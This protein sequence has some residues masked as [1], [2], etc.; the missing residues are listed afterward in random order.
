MAD[1]NDVRQIA[2]SLPGA[3]EVEGRFS[4]TVVNGG[5]AKP[6]AWVWLE[7]VDPRKARVPND[8]VLG[9]RVESVAEKDVLV[10]SQPQKFFTEP[11]YDGYPAVLVRLA[12][13]DVEELRELIVDSWTHQAPRDLRSQSD[14][15]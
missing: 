15:S 2:L 6:F 10:Q 11:H 8:S 5:K 7:R 14:E 4:F 3:V 1:Q 13:I 9:V 12:N